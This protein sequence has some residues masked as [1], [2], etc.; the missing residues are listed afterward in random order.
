MKQLKFLAI[1]AIAALMMI[2]ACKKDDNTSAT[3]TTPT[4]NNNT[5]S[6]TFNATI[7]GSPFVSSKAQATIDPSGTLSISATSG[8]S[9]FAI[10]I[11][12]VKF[13]PNTLYFSNFD[14]A[15]Y[16]PD[17]TVNHAYISD[18]GAVVNITTYNTSTKMIA[19][20]FAYTMRDSLGN[21]LSVTSGNFSVKYSTEA[22]TG[23]TVTYAFDGGS[24][25]TLNVSAGSG[26][27][28]SQDTLGNRDSVPDIYINSAA[29]Q[30]PRMTLIVAK[31][32][33]VGTHDLTKR[34]LGLRE[35]D[36]NFYQTA[37]DSYYYNLSYY[38]YPSAGTVSIT[39]NDQTNHL[40]EGSFNLLVS[41]YDS[42][43][44]VAK[45][46]SG[47]FSVSYH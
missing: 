34:S 30:Y 6:G 7:N 25:N 29:A 3:G 18:D 21:S 39:K 27:S 16:L 14:F 32:A 26:Y 10:L 44:V 12:N 11:N 2:N 23:G 47:N 40:L 36:V 8:K 31:D 42:S 24:T 15:V 19:G 45:S 35:F 17:T 43:G 28:I 37:N 5:S 46:I 20:T 9:G 1:T 33:T 22:Q 41:K 38:T 4:N 13:G